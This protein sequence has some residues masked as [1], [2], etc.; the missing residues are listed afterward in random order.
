MRTSCFQLSE[1]WGYILQIDN[2]TISHLISSSTHNNQLQIDTRHFQFLI[3]Q[4]HVSR[5][6]S[7][8]SISVRS[9]PGAP[10]RTTRSCPARRRSSRT[11]RSSL[12]ISRTPWLS[13]T[14]VRI[15][16]KII[17]LVSMRR[18]SCHSRQLSSLFKYIF[19]F[20]ISIPFPL[21]DSRHLNQEHLIVFIAPALSI[22]IS[23]D[24]SQA[25]T[26]ANLPS[27]I[28]LITLSDRYSILVRLSSW[29]GVTTA[30]SPSLVESLES[31]I[32]THILRVDSSCPV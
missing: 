21:K 17:F 30:P 18:S 16:G 9:P 12:F 29:L 13:P 11:R 8:E 3:I 26:A 27:T 22:K 24:C 5:T 7:Q 23:V 2:L 1:Q 20:S 14:L 6:L 10:W 4:E 25:I 31:G 28:L 15:T 32:N 19:P